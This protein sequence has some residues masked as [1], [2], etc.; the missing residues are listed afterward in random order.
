MDCF[1]HKYVWRKCRKGVWGGMAACYKGRGGG[2]VLKD[3]ELK[4]TWYEIFIHSVKYPRPPSLRHH[5]VTS[6]YG[7]PAPQNNLRVA[8]SLSF[9][10]G[11]FGGVHRA[12][13][14]GSPVL[15]SDLATTC[16]SFTIRNQTSILFGVKSSV[17]SHFIN[18][19]DA[20]ASF[21]S[22]CWRLVF[23]QT[24]LEENIKY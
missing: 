10:N 17:A 13:C 5:L 22:Y 12:I 15:I 2:W 16:S 11:K 19:T 21:Y 14:C 1:R 20:E 18:C 4:I 6:K 24:F 23:E 8:M 7:R 3:E 9:S